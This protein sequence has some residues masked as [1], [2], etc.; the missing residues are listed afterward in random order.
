MTEQPRVLDL[1]RLM[2]PMLAA[3]ETISEQEEE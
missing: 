3:L 1:Y 2:S